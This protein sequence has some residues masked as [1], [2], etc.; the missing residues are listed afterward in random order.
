MGQISAYEKI[1]IEDLR[2]DF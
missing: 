1:V 2:K